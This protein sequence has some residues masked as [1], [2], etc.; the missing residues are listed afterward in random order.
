MFRQMIVGKRAAKKSGGVCAVCDCGSN[1]MD[2][3]GDVCTRTVHQRKYAA[4]LSAAPKL[5]VGRKKEM[6]L[7]CNYHHNAVRRGIIKAANA[8]LQHQQQTSYLWL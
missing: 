4:Q 7:V 6:R 3:F 8:E 5:N 1:S 2:M